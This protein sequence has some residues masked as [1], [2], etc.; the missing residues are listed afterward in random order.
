MNLHKYI[1]DI[2]DFPKKGILY[3]DITPLLSDAKAYNHLIDIFYKRYRNR[4]IDKIIG[5]E[6][7]GFILGS[8]LSS[9]LK[10]GFIPI[11]KPNKLPFKKFSKSFE[12]EYGKDQIEI[13]IDAIKENENV[14]IIDDVLATGGTIMAGIELVSEFNCNLIECAFLLE[15]Q[16]L[17]GQERLHKKGITFF[18]VLK[19]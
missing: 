18:S 5:I 2:A 7:R 13:H 16:S 11:R 14:I 9:M 4:R 10:V 17:K 15:L 3:K 19:T 12:L 8:S 6:S 1:R